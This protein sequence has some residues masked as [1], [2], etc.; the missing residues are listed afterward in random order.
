MNLRSLAVLLAVVG[1]G[2]AC[3]CGVKLRA[4]PDPP[5]PPP[6]ACDAPGAVTG[7]V[8]APDDRT[9]LA[10]AS[11]EIAGADCSGKIFDRK[12]TSAADGTF[13]LSNVPPGQWQMVTSLGSFS[14]TLTVNVPSA[15]K[16]VLPNDANCL[17]SVKAAV[18]TAHGD[19][20]EQLLGNLKVTVTSFDGTA[21]G[22]ASSAQPLLTNLDALKKFDIVFIDCATAAAKGQIDVRD[23]V[24]IAK[25]L[26]DYVMQGGSLYASDWAFLFLA[27]AFPDRFLFDL[28]GT[29]G[30]PANPFD[31]TALL[32]YAPQEVTA[33]VTD[34]GLATFLGKST[35]NVSF[36]LDRTTHLITLHW[37]LMADAPAGVNVLLAGDAQ[38]CAPNDRKCKSA[39]GTAMNIPLAVQF[40][41]APAGVRGGNVVYTSFHNVEQSTND[42]EQILKYL[43]FHL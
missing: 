2:A 25:T 37:G 29:P 6:N 28:N 32:G 27:L 40:H 20:I 15:A 8:C 38:M 13:I 26:H 31:T 33:N 30:Q 16:D 7:R 36:P 5:P 10:G 14:H 23:D 4:V 12:T 3:S 24:A 17:D 41:A 35:V 43:I 42:V 11:V 18:V 22:Y 39:A 1:Q 21:A 34:K 19:R 9:W